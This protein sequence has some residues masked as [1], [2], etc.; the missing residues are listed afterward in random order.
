MESQGK[1]IV[2]TNKVVIVTGAASGIGRAAAQ[3]YTE[4]DYRVVAVDRDED[5][6]AL[7]AEQIDVTA[8]AGD[9]ADDA[10]NE[11][12]VRLALRRYGRLD[13]AV[14]NAGI[15]GAG[16]LESPGALDRFDRVLSVNVRAVASGIR[17]AV[18]ALRA[19]GGGAI[20]ATS[21]VSGL[22]GDPGTWAYNATKAAVI[23]LVRGLALDYAVENIRIN[24]I[25]PGLTLTAMT[26]AQVAHPTFGPAVTARIP[27]QRWAD[28]REQAEVI[29][30]L[31]SPAASYITGTA[32]SVDGGLSA[33]GGLLLPP[34]V[35]GE[36][37]H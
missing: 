3:L 14:L 30:F 29:W 10:T 13:A 9:V 15:G 7:L 34:T 26:A 19:A 11:A 24:A 18:P 2:T 36:A 27:L 21:S 16:P 5:G 28:P 23:N 32:V 31:T 6:L 33:N 4:R 25:A 20:V 12:A 8:L 37:P 17:A 22:R 1:A 35:P